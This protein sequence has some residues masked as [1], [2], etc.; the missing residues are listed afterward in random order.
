M[1]AAPGRGR[2]ASLPAPDVSPLVCPGTR[3][4]ELDRGAPWQR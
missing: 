4:P 3:D 1:S 2:R